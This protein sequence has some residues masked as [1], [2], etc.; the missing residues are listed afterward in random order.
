MDLDVEG[1]EF[2]VLKG[3]PFETHKVGAWVIEHNNEEEKRAAVPRLSP[4]GTHNDR[5]AVRC[6]WN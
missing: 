4:F 3:W 5:V 1:L 2:D 6:V